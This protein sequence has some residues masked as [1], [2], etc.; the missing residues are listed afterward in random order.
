[1]NIFN[2]AE[3]I[4]EKKLNT[5]RIFIFLLITFV[6]TYGIEI[7]VIMPMVG[8]SDINKAYLAQAL[9]AAVM[10][11]PAVST[12]IT[13]LLTGEKLIAS[14][15]MLSLKLKGNLK[16]YAIA[17]FGVAGLIFVGAV[18]Y[19]LIFPSQFDGNMGYAAV[20]FEAQAQAQGIE[21]D[22][23]AEQM[24]Q[25]MAVQILIGIF[26]SPLLN[27]INCFGEEWG[28]RG[29]LLPKMMKRFKI[30]P[31]LLINGIIWGLWHAPLTA[32]GHNYGIGYQGYPVTGILAMCIFCT[33]IG[34][35][36]SYVTIKTGSCFPAV[37]GHAVLNG[38]SGV[39]IYFTS[40]E[41]PYNV[42]L[43][44]SPVGLIGGIGFIVLAVILI[45]LLH[46]EEMQKNGESLL[47]FDKQGATIQEN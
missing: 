17:W 18:L 26:L 41:N 2:Q 4:S 23:S 46:K 42:F 3:D 8:S 14:D 39:G 20:L 47:Q 34:V 36:L 7:F 37:I 22:T 10:F 38:L 43:G 33:V 24:R 29:Y 25:M 45:Y 30:I 9:V 35:I 40:L 13:R 32:M 16:Y 19:F 27:F 21:M 12:L 5:R 44:P 6:L 31:T 15:A 11:L 1:M 28:W